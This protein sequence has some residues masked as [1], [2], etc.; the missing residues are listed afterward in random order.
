MSRLAQT[1][2]KNI[3]KKISFLSIFFKTFPYGNIYLVG[4]AVR[5]LFLNRK[6][7]D[8]DLVI[9]H[10]PKNKLELFLQKYGNL[11]F[12]E[13]KFGTYKFIF[14]NNPDLI[15]DI[16]L[17]RTEESL[18][19]S[20]GGYREFSIKSQKDLPIE[21][22][23]SRRDFTINAMAYNLR[24]KNLID[25]FKGKQDLQKHLI[26]S[27]GDAKQRFKED[28]SR[29]LRAIRFACE[30]QFSLSR[31]MVQT[32]KN[33]SVQ[34]DEKNF[35]V[36]KE[37]KAREFIKSF[38]SDPIQSICLFERFDLLKYVFSIPFSFQKKTIKRLKILQQKKAPLS[39]L[40]VGLI[41]D[42]PSQE[43]TIIIRELRFSGFPTNCPLYINQK[44]INWLLAAT[45]SLKTTKITDLSN[46][47]FEKCFLAPPSA[48]LLLLLQAEKESNP[49]QIDPTVYQI[50]KRINELYRITNT[51]KGSL[52]APLITA[53]DILQ[54]LPDLPKHQIGKCL[55]IVREK[56]LQGTFKTRGQV[57]RW[58]KSQS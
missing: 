32:I 35:Q 45:Y 47:E 18:S 4:G 26:R 48:L 53:L 30:L 5:D 28:H 43:Q 56:Q 50:Q 17:P 7:N 19:T 39:L 36:S 12:V 27:V 25:P 31:S 13:K 2:F 34:I 44:E 16:A 51:P 57:L 14:K 15:F 54:Y 29:V 46:V 55:L 52:I 8:I 10:V 58:L 24:L 23:L 3:E 6:T 38:F 21:K 42:L 49:K 20:R 22:D 9:Q 37:I 40:L 41:F 1:N 33:F 11:Y